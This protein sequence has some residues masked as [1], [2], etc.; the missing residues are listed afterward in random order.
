MPKILLLWTLPAGTGSL[1]SARG[2]AQLL[3]LCPAARAGLCH[4][5]SRP[6]TRTG[7]QHSLQFPWMT[8][9]LMWIFHPSSLPLHSAPQPGFLAAHRSLSSLRRGGRCLGDRVCKAPPAPTS[10]RAGQRLPLAWAPASLTGQSLRAPLVPGCG[11]LAGRAA[12]LWGALCG[13]LLRPKGEQSCRGER[14]EFGG[15]PEPAGLG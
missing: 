5:R 3:Q 11:G 2:H 4:P 1:P 6:Q 7:S 14:D 9:M 13:T 12:R 8:A 10:C 15:T